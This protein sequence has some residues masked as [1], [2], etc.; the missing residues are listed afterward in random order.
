MSANNDVIQGI[1]TAWNAGSLSSAV[2][3]GL[4]PLPIPRPRPTSPYATIQVRKD[5]R[6]NLLTSN[7][8]YIDYR[9]VKITLYG[10]GQTALG[11]VVSSV[12]A[13]IWKTAAGWI[14]LTIPNADWLR[15]EYVSDDIEIEKP[16]QGEDVR[17]TPMEF[18]VW[19]QRNQG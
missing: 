15:T 18:I 8:S 1:E 5:G 6:E 11:G 2:P 7:G 16:V 19:S 12:L 10:V 3:G 17:S 4:H 14:P 9:R 13:A